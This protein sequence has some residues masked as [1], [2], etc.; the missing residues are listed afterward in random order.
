MQKKLEKK[1]AA[2]QAEEAVERDR[3]INMHVELQTCNMMVQEAMAK[4]SILSSKK[5]HYSMTVK[6]L[7]TKMKMFQTNKDIFIKTRQTRI[8]SSKTWQR[9]I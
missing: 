1:V 3:A 6:N 4:E 8:Y 9:E 5:K 2:K 7:Q